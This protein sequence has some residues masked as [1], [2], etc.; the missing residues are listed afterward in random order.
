VFPKYNLSLSPK[1][2][3]APNDTLP[4]NVLRP[5]TKIFCAS[6]ALLT[7]RP[8]PRVDTPLTDSLVRSAIP[9]IT[10]VEIPDRGA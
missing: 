8:P 3:E 10:E 1:Y 2:A 4:E 9:P 5:D 7:V 6:S